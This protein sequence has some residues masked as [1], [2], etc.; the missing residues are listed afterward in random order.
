VV[1]DSCRVKELEFDADK[2]LPALVTKL[3]SQDSLRQRAGRAGRVQA[4]RCFRIITEKLYLK[5]AP[6]GTPEI[7]R[8]PL[9]RLVLQVKATAPSIDTRS[10]ALVAQN[11]Q[12]E[13]VLEILQTCLDP[14]A[15]DAVATAVRVLTR[16]QALNSDESNSL[17]AL[18]KLLASLPCAPRIG[19]LLVYGT[20]LGCTF[21]ASCVAACLQTKSPFLSSQP[22]SV[23]ADSSMPDLRSRVDASKVFYIY[24]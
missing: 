21:P 14:P 7:L 17:T 2:Q 8:V 12:T 4:G 1:I 11:S 19:R 5:M 18:G 3:S 6:N 23:T 24:H 10:S 15:R 13:D 16:I 20:L 9:D 22:P